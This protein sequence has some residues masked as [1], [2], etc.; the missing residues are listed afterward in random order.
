VDIRL[1]TAEPTDAEREAIDTV[2]G[3]AGV[4]GHRVATCCCRRSAR[5]SGASAG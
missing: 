5:R 4:D 1:L 2:T 3:P